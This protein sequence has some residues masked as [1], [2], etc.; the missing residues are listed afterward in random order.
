MSKFSKQPTGPS[1]GQAQAA[2]AAPAKQLEP[3]HRAELSLVLNRMSSV[4]AVF[5]VRTDSIP[6]KRFA[7]FRESWTSISARPPAT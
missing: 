7:A 4:A 5:Q 2:P 6:N 1:Q 3:G